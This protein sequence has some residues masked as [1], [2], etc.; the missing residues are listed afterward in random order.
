MEDLTEVRSTGGG[1]R[2]G[3]YRRR[4][5]AMRRKVLE[6]TQGRLAIPTPAGGAGHGCSLHLPG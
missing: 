4:A 3:R 5:G 2:A 6:E 1:E